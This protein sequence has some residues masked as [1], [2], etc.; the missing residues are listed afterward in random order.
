MSRSVTPLLS[1]GTD[2]LGRY[3]EARV[4]D[5]A[6]VQVAGAIARAVPGTHP[7][8]L[9][10][11]ALCVRALRFGH[12]CVELDRVRDTVAA[13]HDHGHDQ[14]ASGQIP[15]RGHKSYVAPRL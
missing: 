12:V 10:G 2:A 11:I 4:F 13:E 7:D 15:T 6:D 3:V 1:E 14:S 9:V 5:E 8:V